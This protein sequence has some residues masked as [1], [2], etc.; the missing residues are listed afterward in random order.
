M[1]P[2]QRRWTENRPISVPCSYTYWEAH[3]GGLLFLILQLETV[4]C[5]GTE[6]G[7]LLMRSLPGK[8]GEGRH[9]ART[10]RP[11]VRVPAAAPTCHVNSSWDQLFIS[12]IFCFMFYLFLRESRGGAREG[13]ERKGDRGSKAGSALTAARAP[14]GA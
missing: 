1:L 9:R 8:A 12:L 7:R 2:S 11:R 13:A 10:W 5:L 3:V 4:L 6:A 14:C